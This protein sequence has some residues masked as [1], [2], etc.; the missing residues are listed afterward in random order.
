MMKAPNHIV[1]KIFLAVIAGLIVAIIFLVSLFI[2]YKH[3]LAN[4]DEAAIE[5]RVDTIVIYKHDTVVC[6]VEKFINEIVIDTLYL[7]SADTSLPLIKKE[8]Y[9]LPVMQRYYKGSNYAAW[10]SGYNPVLDSLHFSPVIE[11]KYIDHYLIKQRKSKKIALYIDC[12]MMWYD[13][14]KLSPS[15]RL[16]LVTPSFSFGVGTAYLDGKFGIGLN[17][18]YKLF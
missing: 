15:A 7:P 8:P 12:G 13:K 5:Y 9:M 17:I 6:E 4:G 1:S 10:V 14:T 3:N 2:Q 18:G 11:Q 16:N